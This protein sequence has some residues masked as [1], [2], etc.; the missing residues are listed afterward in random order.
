[1][2]T[3]AIGECGYCPQDAEW[4]LVVEQAGKYRNIVTCQDCADSTVSER[5]NVIDGHK[6][7]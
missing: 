1:M 2:N 4:V 3:K 7:E 5:F 6:Y